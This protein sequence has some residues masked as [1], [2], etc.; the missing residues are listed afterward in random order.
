[1]RRVLA[2][3]REA[4]ESVF[5]TLKRRGCGAAGF[6]RP[7]WVYDD[8]AHWFH[9]GGLLGLTARR[10]AHE[11]GLYEAAHREATSLDLLTQ[12]TRKRPAP[13]PTA[14]ELADVVTRRRLEPIQAPVGWPS[15][16][17]IPVAR[18]DDYDEM[19]AA[20]PDR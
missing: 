19:T 7:A 3:R 17:E 13:G 2:S 10:L 6:D 20:Y 16:E 11:L 12:P 1:M 5:A 4:V 14:D 18:D 8:E 15:Y 9:Y